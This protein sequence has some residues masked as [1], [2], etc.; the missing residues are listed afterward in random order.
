MTSHDAELEVT[1]PAELAAIARLAEWLQAGC[2]RLQATAAQTHAVQVCAEE[3]V[4]NV[5]LHGGGAS[6]VRVRLLRPFGL[7]IE[8][9]GVAF[10]PT[11]APP[12]APASNLDEVAIGGLGLGLVRHFALTMAYRRL[13]GWNLVELRFAEG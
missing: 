12:P 8:D 4:A 3:L 7:V 10:D 11:A 9:D 5:V 6:S 13:G 1:L 2:T